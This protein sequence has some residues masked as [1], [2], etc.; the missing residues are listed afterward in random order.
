MS[1]AG[2]SDGMLAVQGAGS[3]LPEAL[4]QDTFFACPYGG[5]TLN[6]WGDK[7][8]YIVYRTHVYKEG[9]FL[10]LKIGMND[11]QVM[12]MTAVDG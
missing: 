6:I 2:A 5:C 10:S 3:T 11:W 9:V 4:F 8:M 12:K 1:V 7:Y